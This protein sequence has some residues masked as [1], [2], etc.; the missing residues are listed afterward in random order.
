VSRQKQK[1]SRV[2]CI[3]SRGT[4]VIYLGGRLP[5]PLVRPTRES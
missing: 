1:I 5:G 3:P 4:A 2:L